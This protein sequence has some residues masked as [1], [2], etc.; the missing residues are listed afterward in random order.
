VF[1]ALL[2]DDGFA[3]FEGHVQGYA[4]GDAHDALVDAMRAFA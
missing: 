4:L 1:R 2:G 3:T